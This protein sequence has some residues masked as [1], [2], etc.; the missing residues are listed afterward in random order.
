VNRE[1]GALRAVV[2]LAGAFP[3]ETESRLRDLVRGH[4]QD[5]VND[6][7]PA[8]SRHAAT[9]TIIPPR[10]ADSLKVV[11]SLNPSGAGQQTAQRELVQA[12]ETALERAPSAHHPERV[13][14]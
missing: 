12:I 5:A 7:W 9:L 2:I 11:L 10:L 4:I 8:M 3:G 6:E 13:V 1:A 14:D